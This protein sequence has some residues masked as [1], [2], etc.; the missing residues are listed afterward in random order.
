MVFNDIRA[1]LETFLFEPSEGSLVKVSDSTIDS[2][3]GENPPRF[4]PN[5][6][7]LSFH[8]DDPTD[9]PDAWSLHSPPDGSATFFTGVALAA[10]LDG[11]ASD[12]PLD[13][14]RDACRP[15][16]D[17]DPMPLGVD[18]VVVVVSCHHQRVRTG[19]AV[20]SREWS[21]K[22]SRPCGFAPWS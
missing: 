11:P 22:T 18:R 16:F 1:P 19:S 2:G 4:S 14:E 12:Y 5:G 7:A 10:T 3:L 20:G 8:A 17:R 9:R 13:T 15:Y 6:S 21:P